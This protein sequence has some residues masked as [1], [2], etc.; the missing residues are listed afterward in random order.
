MIQ[1]PIRQEKTLKEL[2]VMAVKAGTTEAMDELTEVNVQN[3]QR[4]G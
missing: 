3:C 1:G 2:T 4:I